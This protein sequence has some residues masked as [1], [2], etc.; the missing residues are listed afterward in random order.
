M[1]DP[2]KWEGEQRT[3]MHCTECSKG[4]VALLNYDIDGNHIVECPWCGHEHC[5]VIK[6]GRV[7]EERWSSRTQRPDTVVDKRNVWKSNV[8]P[9]RTTSASQFLSELW[10]RRER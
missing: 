2:Y 1:T 5:R 4:F 6:D 9:A 8:L 3:D 7:T 10:L